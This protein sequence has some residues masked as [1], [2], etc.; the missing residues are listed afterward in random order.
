MKFLNFLEVK[1]SFIKDGREVWQLCV[2]VEYARGTSLHNGEVE[3][4]LRIK[5]PEWRRG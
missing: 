3:E 4:F 2:D 5:P 1:R